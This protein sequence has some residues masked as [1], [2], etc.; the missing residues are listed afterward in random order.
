M[1]QRFTEKQGFPIIVTVCT[2]VITA[3]ALWSQG[4]P[5]LTPA[6]TESTENVSAAQLEQQLLCDAATTPPPNSTPLPLCPPLKDCI[7]LQPYAEHMVQ[8][9]VTGLWQIHAAVDLRASP[10]EEVCA[11][12]DGLI[13]STGSSRISGDWIIINHGGGLILRYAGVK[14]SSQLSSGERVRTGEIIGIIG[15]SPLDESNLGPHL[16][17]QASREGIF[18]DPTTLWESPK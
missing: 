17:L 8:S 1:I 2:A 16:H 6:P 7:V 3:T 12:A 15:T 5:E 4:H 13:L 9:S 14:A 11:A 18:I 10:A